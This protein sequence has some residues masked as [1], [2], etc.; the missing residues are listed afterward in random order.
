MGTQ[1]DHVPCFQFTGEE[2]KA[3]ANMGTDRRGGQEP[4]RGT[5]CHTP[6]LWIY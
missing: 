3:Q 5:L 4:R 6:V 2:T 1:G